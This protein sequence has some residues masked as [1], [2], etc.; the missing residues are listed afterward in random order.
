MKNVYQLKSSEGFCY[1]LKLKNFACFETE[2][3]NSG[4]EIVYEIECF[5]KLELFI[6]FTATHLALAQER[7]KLVLSRLFC[8][9][10]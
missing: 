3:V 8:R 6:F 5:P 2:V 7:I 10:K 1:Q 4:F 9:S